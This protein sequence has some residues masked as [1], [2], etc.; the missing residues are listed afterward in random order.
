MNLPGYNFLSAPLWLITI[1]HVV[2]LSLHFV[3]MN[4][5]FGGLIVVL[6]GK[7]DD[8][9]RDA[10]V[11]R[12]VSLFPTAV[13]VTVTMGVAPL[14][15]LQLTYYQQVY[16]ASIV[17][18]W[19]W[20]AIVAAVTIGYY[21]FY[22]AAFSSKNKPKRLPVYL[23]I[24]LVM[25]VY[26]SFVYSTVF[27]MAERPDI[28]RMLYA[29]N[30]SGLVVNTNA[31]TWLFRWL[32]M[33]LGAVAVGG[34]FV[35]LVG[36]NNEPVYSVG[37]RFFLWGVIAAAVLGVV[38]L[39]TLGKHLRPF[40]RAPAIWLVVGAFVLTLLSL[41]FFAKKK[42]FPAALVLFVSIV[43]MVSARHNLRLIV[44]EGEFDPATIPVSPQ[45][46]AFLMFL[47]CFVIA[48]GA[49]WYMLRLFFADRQQPA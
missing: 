18:A 26:V 45:W 5:L 6:L 29:G 34:F 37:K 46:S 14:L 3:A 22:G 19:P 41:H 21:F 27:S 9:W 33:I 40:M 47:I 8:K 35:G 30:Q 38:Y 4:F 16:S 31:G 17:S 13:A 11:A 44:L 2:T 12:L 1:L 7:I 48:I 49:V 10:T 42:F 20:I 43:G 24:G 15:F 25:L 32:H 28:Y 23:T 36:R 39:L